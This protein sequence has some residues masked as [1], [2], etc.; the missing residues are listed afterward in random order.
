MISNVLFNRSSEKRLHQKILRP[1]RYGHKFTLW[2][3]SQDG[4]GTPICRFL[5]GY[6]VPVNRPPFYTNLIPNDPPFFLNPDPMTPI[7]LLTYQSL[8]TNC[9]FLHTSHTFW[10]I[11][12]FCG[13]FNIKCSN[14]GLKMHFCPLN[15]P[16]FWESTSKKIPV[17]EPTL[18][19]PFFQQN[20]TLNAT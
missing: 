1:L 2:D 19:D 18:D 17:L 8:H 11:Y 3:V 6:Q 15:D 14:F 4:G 13:Y 20:L 10:K 16:H 7:F 5:G 9:K 12:K